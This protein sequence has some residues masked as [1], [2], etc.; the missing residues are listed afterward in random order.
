[1]YNM[2]IIG[3]WT[4]PTDLH[5]N[6]LTIVELRESI[7][8]GTER[9]SYCSPNLQCP[10]NNATFKCNL[11]AGY[12]SNHDKV[13]RHIKKETIKKLAPSNVDRY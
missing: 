11:C 9:A 4:I 3:D 10:K 13:L 5:Y 6:T 12:I 7:L 2:E 1:M 8:K